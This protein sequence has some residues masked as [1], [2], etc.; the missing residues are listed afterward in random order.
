[1][2]WQHL[3]LA[4]SAMDQRTYS[5]SS[6]VY[7]FPQAVTNFQPEESTIKGD[8]ALEATSSSSTKL[9]PQQRFVNRQRGPQSGK[10]KP[11]DEGY[12][13]I[14]HGKKRT[15]P[16]WSTEGTRVTMI[17]LYMGCSGDT[18]CSAVL[19]RHEKHERALRFI[20]LLAERN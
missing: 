2:R 10:Y 5:G 20:S 16:G 9:P 17:S 19:E 12:D 13:S 15:I 14:A 11:L 1:M 3:R 4:C 7:L 8:V 6:S 18:S